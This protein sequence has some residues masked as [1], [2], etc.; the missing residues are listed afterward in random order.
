LTD[1]KLFL[2]KRHRRGNAR[3]TLR[4]KFTFSAVTTPICSGDGETL[5][6]SS[7]EL[8]FTTNESLAVGQCLQV[9][10]DWPACLEN[11]IPLKLVVSAISCKAAMVRQ[12]RPFEKYEFRVGGMK[13]PSKRQPVK[14]MLSE[15]KPTLRVCDITSHGEASRK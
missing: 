14:A 8:M 11:R 10:L 4:L 9:L 15:R 7:N 3:Y 2:P 13:A 1:F 6:I 5:R 12:R